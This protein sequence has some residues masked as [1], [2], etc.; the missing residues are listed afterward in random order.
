MLSFAVVVL[1]A[2]FVLI[3]VRQVGR[4][5]FQ[6]WHVMLGGALAVFV[7]FQ[8]SPVDAFNAVNKIGRAHV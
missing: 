5:R 2:V 6:I 3:A 4:F 8:I 1:F 7:T